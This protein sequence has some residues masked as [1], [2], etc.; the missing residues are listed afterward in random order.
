MAGFGNYGAFTNYD[1]SN[2]NVGTSSN[3]SL[4]DLSNQWGSYVN[5]VNNND[6]AGSLPKFNYDP[7]QGNQ[8]QKDDNNDYANKLQGSI[9]DSQNASN[10]DAIQK[11]QIA[12][13]TAMDAANLAQQKSDAASSRAQFDR[14]NPNGKSF[15]SSSVLDPSSREG[16]NAST[17]SN[18]NSKNAAYGQSLMND[19]EIS[20]QSRLIPMQ[21]QAT[22]Q[23]Q[24]PQFQSAQ[25]VADIQAEAS[26]AVALASQ[27]ANM[28]GANL[29]AMSSMFGSQ[30]GAVG[31]MFGGMSG[32]GGGGRYW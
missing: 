32:G 29:N 7:K 28:Y 9:Y 13:G 16:Q 8:S 22:I 3:K 11:K 19:A 25:K 1:F 20:K 30:M 10:A 4:D 23:T 18:I 15:S 24:A 17:W 14:T 27:Q 31:S 5:S 21:T 12:Y 2:G 26:K 6:F